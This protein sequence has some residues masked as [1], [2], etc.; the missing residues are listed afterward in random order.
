[1]SFKQSAAST[2]TSAIL[3]IVAACG[4]VPAVASA[5]TTISRVGSV[6]TITGDSAASR[7]VAPDYVTDISI[8]D[9]LPGGIVTAGPGCIQVASNQAGCGAL[10]TESDKIVVNLGGGDDYY[11][12]AIVIDVPQTV[13]GEGGNDE[14]E[15]GNGKDT[16]NGGPGNDEL[17]GGRGDDTL[18]GGEGDDVVDG[19]DG[20]DTV[21]GGPGKDRLLGDGGTVYAGGS[22]TIQARD[23]EADTVDCGGGADRAVVDTTDVVA[24]CASVELPVG[25]GGSGGSGGSGGTGGTGGS[26]G[27]GG[28]S[29]TPELAVTGTVTKSQ[30]LGALAAGKKITLTLSTNATCSGKV[31]LAVTKAEARRLKLGTSALVLGTS[32]TTTFNATTLAGTPVSVGVDGKYRKKLKSASKL[33]TTVTIACV[34]SAKR[35]YLGSL[36]VTFKR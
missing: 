36:S 6:V 24:G 12:R 22:D 19:W 2:F 26:G 30:K 10:F 5:T 27:S 11:K 23:G 33:K 32:K 15:T 34:D 4:L 31:A 18:D 14:I 16:V 8:Q 21:I 17:T 25:G 13:N 29:T 1:M 7:I 9:E 20:S 28:S 35:S 3:A